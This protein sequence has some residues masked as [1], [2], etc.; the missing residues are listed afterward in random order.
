M[1]TLTIIAS[2]IFNISIIINII[3]C[4]HSDWNATDYRYHGD[5]PIPSGDYKL[6]LPLVMQYL[7]PLP[8]AIIGLG[9]VSAAV[10]SSADSSMLSASSMFARNIYEPLR[11]ACTC[12]YCG[13][14]NVVSAWLWK[15]EVFK[16]A[17]MSCVYNVT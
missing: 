2:A 10:M 8:V 14:S 12:C 3:I 15:Q 11:N 1:L 7:T 4:Y 17:I 5:V 9:A 6:V 16:I 13:G